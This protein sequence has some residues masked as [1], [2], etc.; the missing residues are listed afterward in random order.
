MHDCVLTHDPKHLYLLDNGGEY[1]VRG[2]FIDKD[3][4]R[5]VLKCMNEKG[6][7][8]ASDLNM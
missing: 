5:P 6:W 2:Y 7:K 1:V 4:T 3:T 8:T